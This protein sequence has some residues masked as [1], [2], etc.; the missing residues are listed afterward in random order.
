M[1]WLVQEVSDLLDA[2]SVG[3]YEFIELLDDPEQPLPTDK[4]RA[5]AGQALGHLLDQR[6]VRLH[7]MRWPAEDD[8]GAISRDELPADPWQGFDEDGR[9]LAISRT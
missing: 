1:D 2:S 7:W 9:Y 4:M 6:G 3:L 5:V 8:L